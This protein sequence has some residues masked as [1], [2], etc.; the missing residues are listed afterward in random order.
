ME[1]KEKS[2]RKIVLDKISKIESFYFKNLSE[3]EEVIIA[4]TVN[5]ICENAFYDCPNLKKVFIPKSVEIIEKN[6]FINCPKLE[7]FC[8]KE[9][10]PGWIDTIEIKEIEEEYISP[11]DDAF[12]FHRSS[13]GW[14]YSTYIRKVENKISWN[15]CG[16]KVHTNCIKKSGL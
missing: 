6:A 9:P 12:N 14:N 7:I 1:N 16:Y 10:Q 5:I 13:G 2:T 8:E 15:P 11:D 4:S 3:V